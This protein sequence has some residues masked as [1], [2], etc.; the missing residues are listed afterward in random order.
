VPQ[1]LAQ[2]YEAFLASLKTHKGW[3]AGG[4]G[5][6]VVAVAAVLVVTYGGFFGPSGKGICTAVLKDA[7][8]YGVLPG[9]ATLVGDEAKKTDVK[10]HRVCTAQTGNNKYL[11]TAAITCSKVSDGKCVT[12]YAVESSDG[13]STYQ[14]RHV[15][16]DET[17]AVSGEIPPVDNSRQPQQ[18][19]APP[20][21]GAA[22]QQAAAPQRSAP[23][24]TDDDLQT[25]KPSGNVGTPVQPPAPQQ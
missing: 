8:S 17:A 6:V 23:S 18:Q 20:D 10:D 2:L 22:P 16:D 4:G 1:S 24:D 12:L 15:P 13:L 5:I 14:L 19:S 11:I 7:T 3:W 21:Q 25:V 9:D